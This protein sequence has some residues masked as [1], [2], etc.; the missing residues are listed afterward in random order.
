VLVQATSISNVVRE[1]ISF[2]GR[3]A[4][5]AATIPLVALKLHKSWNSA[6]VSR[7]SMCRMLY[8]PLFCIVVEGTIE[9]SR[10]ARG[11]SVV[12]QFR[13]RHF[14][15]V[16]VTLGPSRQPFLIQIVLFIACYMCLWVV[17]LVAHAFIEA[18]N[19]ADHVEDRNML[20]SQGRIGIF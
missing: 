17:L 15:V 12:D 9:L 7:H 18:K 20:W 4:H 5:R 11:T 19:I 2:I 6:F 3:Y 1:C 16:V 14:N 10:C 13:A 8:F